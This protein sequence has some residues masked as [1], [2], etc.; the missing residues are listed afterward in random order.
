M[1]WMLLC[2]PSLLLR[3]LQ[4]ASWWR[5]IVQAVAGCHWSQHC[6][7]A[8][9]HLPR[10]QESLNPFFYMQRRWMHVQAAWCMGKSLVPTLGTTI[11]N[12][13]RCKHRSQLCCCSPVGLPPQTQLDSQGLWGAVLLSSFS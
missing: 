7:H 13:Q 11:S 1:Q 10:A 5:P 4:L 8:V 12:K 2:L 9:L 6:I 3:V